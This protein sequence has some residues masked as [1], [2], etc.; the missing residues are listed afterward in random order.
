MG[1]RLVAAVACI[2]VLASLTGMA[3][4]APRRRERVVEI[5][6]LG[7]GVGFAANGNSGGVC[8]IDLFNPQDVCVTAAPQSGERFVHVEF[9]DLAGQKVAGQLMQGGAE[10]ES[11]TAFGEF[12]G[13][14]K[15]PVRLRS[16]FQDLQI[17]YYNG[18]CAT[19]EPSIVT[20]GTIRV[21]F[22]NLP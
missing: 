3:H 7:G 15:K 18:F 11:F 2:A 21:T 20:S 17:N 8:P 4:G 9:V 6:Y 13:A 16:S 22:S 10:A 12:C 5:P 1:R 19:G 14:H